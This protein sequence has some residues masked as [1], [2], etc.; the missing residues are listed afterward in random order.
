[1]NLL[2]LTSLDIKMKKK[3]PRLFFV[4]STICLLLISSAV[5]AAQ[6]TITFDAGTVTRIDRVV[7]TPAFQ[8]DEPVTI[9]FTIDDATPNSSGVAGQGRFEDPNGTITYEGQFSGASIVLTTGII[10]EF[11]S[12][13]HFEIRGVSSATDIFFRGRC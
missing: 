4:N 12:P 9:E 6:R 1:M 3:S 11:D 7:T 2:K 8:L 13:N 5:S 10:I